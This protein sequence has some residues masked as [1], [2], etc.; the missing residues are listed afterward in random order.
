[1]KL[2]DSQ[3]RQLLQPYR[4]RMLRVVMLATAASIV[5]LVLLGVFF[6]AARLATQGKI[7]IRPLDI[8][9]TSSPG[10]MTGIGLA[11]L[12][13]GVA[14]FVMAMVV[15]R[16]S[17]RLSSAALADLQTRA[18]ETH[19]D[20]SLSCFWKVKG[21][22]LQHHII[23]LPN[24]VKEYVHYLPVLISS[25]IMIAVVSIFAA[26]LSWKLFLAAAIAGGIYA[27]ALQKISHHVYIFACRVLNVLGKKLA[28]TSHEALAG[29][30]QIKMFHLEKIWVS[31]FR[32]V[33]LD[34]AREHARHKWWTLLPQ[35]SVELVFVMVFA[36][37]FVS[38]GLFPKSFA[39]LSLSAFL[40]F[41]FGVFRL[42][43]YL[44]QTGR[45]YG[46]MTSALPSVRDYYEHLKAFEAEPSGGSDLPFSKG[47]PLCVEL[48]DV[49][50]S[51]GSGPDVLRHV[52][53]ML[54]PNSVTAIVGLSGSGK[55][56]LID[57]VLGLINPK[58]G[59]VRC[60]GVDVRSI[61]RREW[62]KEAALSSQD[63]FLFH[64]TIERNLA[65]AHEGATREQIMAACRTA[66]VLEFLENQPE[67]INTVVG[68]RGLTLSGGQRQRLALARALLKPSR[69]LILDEPTSALDSQIEE[70]V[71][72]ELWPALRE[73]TTLI[74]SHNLNVIQ[75]AD[76]IHVLMNGAICQSG[77][78]EELMASPGIYRDI[79]T[80]QLQS[81]SPA[82]EPSGE[83]VT[84]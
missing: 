43:P 51:Y 18:L 56:T 64:D 29:I 45:A 9:W 46:Q 10:L 26:F 71:Y 67:G 69:I 20:A 50:F 12:A 53:L 63:S 15:E 30:R 44:I 28:A 74:V 2:W 82:R 62:L 61:K 76:R 36:A 73:R 11:L 40:T 5:E 8:S 83:E 22:E 24:R 33:A 81:G 37:G 77:T 13:V 70:S 48:E 3:I 47:E 1:M 78:H 38:F 55:S 32:S 39:T 21:G 7:E 35:K 79:F 58:S 42:I 59:R 80:T 84:V 25:S 75:R 54:E 34:F 14:K 6:C 57:I 65:A 66:G 4:R 19:L 27:L 60:N 72:R 16:E 68:D 49:S 52:S 17:A 41:I 31:Q 23:H